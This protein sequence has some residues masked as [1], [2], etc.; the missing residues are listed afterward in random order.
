MEIVLLV[1]VSWI[2][3]DRNSTIRKCLCIVVG[4]RLEFGT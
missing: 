1:V 3:C 4:L 2:A